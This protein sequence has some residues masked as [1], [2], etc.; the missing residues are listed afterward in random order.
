VDADGFT[1]SRDVLSGVYLHEGVTISINGD[2]TAVPCVARIEVVYSPVSGV[3]ITPKV[4]IVEEG[5]ARLGLTSARVCTVHMKSQQHTQSATIF[6]SL[7]LLEAVGVATAAIVVADE[8]VI[9]E[10]TVDE[11]A[12]LVLEEGE[13]AQLPCPRAEVEVVEPVMEAVV[14]K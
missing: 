14:L 7:L 12:V 13:P 4:E 2:K 3:R 9:D 1:A 10:A 11:A 8:A 6:Q 5:V